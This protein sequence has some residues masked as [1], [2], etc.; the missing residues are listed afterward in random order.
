MAGFF[1][2]TL[3]ISIVGL[4]SLFILKR[5]EMRGNRVM[6]APMRPGING[7]FHSILV[8]FEY[9]I[10]S[11]LKNLMRSFS[12]IVRRAFHRL[13]ARAM[14]LFEYTLEHV[15]HTVRKKSEAPQGQGEVSMFLQEVAAHK[16]SL[17]KRSAAKRAIFDD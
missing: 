16:K 6:L 17:L 12:A 14:L 13:V 7:F 10:P 15:L 5:Y 4:L 3:G 11:F 8:F 1:T 9:R 2:V